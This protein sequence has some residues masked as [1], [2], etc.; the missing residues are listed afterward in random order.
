M[1]AAS[2]KEIFQAIHPLTYCFPQ[3]P[4]NFWGFL[5]KKVLQKGLSQR[6]LEYIVETLINTRNY[7]TFTIAD[8]FGIDKYLYELSPSEIEHA[9]APMAQ[10]EFAGKYRIVYEEEAKCCGYKYTK[11]EAIAEREAREDKERDERWA[12]E[13]EKM[14]ADGLTDPNAPL[15][16]LEELSKELTEN[17]TIR[18]EKK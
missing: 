1:P 2:E 10:I 16:S 14:V 6:R 5:C 17:Y 12:K 8:F 11:Y 18:N 3:I 4:S 15:K 7:A 9:T 13:Y